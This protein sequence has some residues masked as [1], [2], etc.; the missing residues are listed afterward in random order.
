[1]VETVI[2]E[3]EGKLIQGTELPIVG[4]SHIKLV[5]T[6]SL[7]PV[8]SVVIKHRKKTVT[9]MET[10]R[11]HKEAKKSKKQHTRKQIQSLSNI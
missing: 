8:A 6:L 1:M 3:I 2:V 10:A 11:W 4:H 5:D 7:Q 9:N